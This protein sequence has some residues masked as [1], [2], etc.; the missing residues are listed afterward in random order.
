MSSALQDLIGAAT[1]GADA[2]EVA[3]LPLPE[4][5]RAAVVR[6]DETEMFDGVP[7]AEK[8]P[9]SSL[10]IDTVAIPPLGPNE[11]LVAPMA[12]ALNFNTVW[13]SIFEPLPTFAFLKRFG[14]ESELGARHDLPY[15]IVGSDAAGV[16]VRTGVGVTRWKPGDRVTIHCNYV[17]LEGPEG[18]DDS[19]IDSRQRIWGFET[20]FG[21]MAE[22]TM[23]KANQLMPMPTHLS[24]EEAASLSLTLAT[25]YRMLVS[26]NAGAMKQGDTVLIWG[27]SG[28]LGGY[29]T[30]LVRNG[31][32]I[33]VCV[34][35]SPEKVEL[36]RGLGVEAVIDRKAEGYAFWDGDAQDPAEWKRFGGKIRE[37]TGGEDIDIVFEHPGRSTFGASV[38]VAKKGGKIVTCASTSGYLHE[39]DNRY[40][41]MNLKSIISSHFANYREAW[42]A[43]RLVD[44]GMIHPILTQTY[45]LDRIGDAAWAM[46]TN[47]HTGKLGLLVNAAA[48]GQGIADVDKRSRFADDIDAWKGLS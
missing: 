38:F 39:Y 36:L 4:S 3:A 9:R 48:Q 45:P 32:G 24:W 15:H 46:H 18:H 17:D 44:R 37:L 16:V 28:G 47:Q 25:S 27:A 10:H 11:V 26:Q 8:D 5:M 34:V 7:S 35:S 14:R 43:N 20:N 42:A 19:M 22:L 33:P 21:A 40:L 13:T 12:A 30:Q 2:G 29:A 31:G 41:W 6:A 23:V 1:S